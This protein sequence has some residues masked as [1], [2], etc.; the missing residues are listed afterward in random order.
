MI[1]PSRSDRFGSGTQTGPEIP[2]GVKTEHGIDP[3]AP[4]KKHAAELTEYLS[5]YLSVQSDSIKSSIRSLG[6]YAALGFVGAIALVAMIAKAMTLVLSGAAAGLGE[7]FGDRLWA[8]EL[9]TGVAVFLIL[10]I[11]IFIVMRKLTNSSRQKAIDKYEQRRQTERAKFG[12]DYQQRAA[13]PSEADRSSG[14][15]ADR[16]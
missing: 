12:H 2:P 7:L 3:L 4:L 1:S 6:I 11:T 15:P 9:V 5:C 13:R 14:S 16:R 8:G 10:A